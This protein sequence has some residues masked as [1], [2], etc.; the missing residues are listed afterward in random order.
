[1]KHLNGIS[2]PPAER[3]TDSRF[4][5][6]FGVS[7]WDALAILRLSAPRRRALKKLLLRTG[8]RICLSQALRGLDDSGTG[9][10]ESCEV[11]DELGG[12]ALVLRPRKLLLANEPEFLLGLRGLAKLGKIWIDPGKD[13]P[14]ALARQAKASPIEWIA[15]PLWHPRAAWTSARVLKCHGWHEARWIRYYGPGQL[16]LIRRRAKRAD[17]LLWGHSKREEEGARFAER[18]SS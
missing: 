16:E 13:F 11:R 14:L 17:V 12:L 5:E 8:H 15:D 1:M 4:F 10:Q 7:E 6:N 9:L 18:G 2:N 3:L